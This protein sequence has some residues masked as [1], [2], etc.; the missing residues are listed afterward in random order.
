LLS[1][2]V[3]AIHIGTHGVEIEAGLR[4]AFKSAGWE[5]KADFSLQ[6]K[7]ETPFG[8]ISFDDGVQAWRNPRL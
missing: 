3:R 7:R 4:Q 8:C 2:K 6:G 5:C 1:A